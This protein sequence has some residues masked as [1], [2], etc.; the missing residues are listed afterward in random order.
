MIAYQK[1]KTV[2]LYPI[3]KCVK[4]NIPADYS[5][6]K[7]QN[8]FTRRKS[9]E[10]KTKENTLATLIKTARNDIQA[11]QQKEPQAE[12]NQD[13]KAAKP[14][15]TFKSLFTIE[16]SAYLDFEENAQFLAVG[17]VNG[18]TIVYDINIGIEK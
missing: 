13:K 12:G 1:L 7:L 2:E 15:L 8:D 9:D 14:S 4:E 3:Q 16:S 17:M 11:Q 5:L 10:K 18:G 6:E